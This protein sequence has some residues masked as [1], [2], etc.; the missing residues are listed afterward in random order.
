VNVA[1]QAL[2]PYAVTRIKPNILN[3][4]EASWELPTM[5]VVERGVTRLALLTLAVSV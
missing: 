5:Q 4:E 3:A 2:P 1:G